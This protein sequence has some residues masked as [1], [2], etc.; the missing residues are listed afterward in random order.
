MPGA[1]H[2]ARQ[3]VDIPMI[4]TAPEHLQTASEWRHIWTDFGFSVQIIIFN[5]RVFNKF[6]DFRI[7]LLFGV[8]EMH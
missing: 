4:L 8:M 2:R 3:V 5:A 7:F 1:V 6:P